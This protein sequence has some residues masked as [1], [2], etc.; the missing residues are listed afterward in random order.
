MSSTIVFGQTGL[1]AVLI[2][3]VVTEIR[4]YLASSSS[5]SPSDLQILSDL[6]TVWQNQIPLGNSYFGLMDT[7]TFFT[8]KGVDTYEF[9]LGQI[10]SIQGPNFL[11][12]NVPA[13]IENPDSKIAFNAAFTPVSDPIIIAEA[14]GSQGPFTHTVGGNIARG[15]QNLLGVFEPQVAINGKDNT[16]KTITLQEKGTGI[17]YYESPVGTFTPY[18]TVDYDTGVVRFTMP[19]PIYGQVKMVYNPSGFGQPMAGLF[20]NNTIQLKPIPNAAYRILVYVQYAPN[21]FTSLQQTLPFPTYKDFL[22]KATALLISQRNY[23]A[24]KVAQL[25]LLTQEASDRILNTNKKNTTVR[26]ITSQFTTALNV[27]SSSNPT[28]INPYPYSS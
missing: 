9:P 17:L 22:V 2:Q 23:D 18:G 28:F 14:G 4:Q 6:N 27:R 3:Q 20:C 5:G 13:I 24:E 12:D 10:L 25:A 1:A 15:Y 26:D 21:P 19:V 16:G 7:W 8:Q 11:V